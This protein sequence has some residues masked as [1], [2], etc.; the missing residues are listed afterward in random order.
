[1]E[2]WNEKQ[3]TPFN[4]RVAVVKNRFYLAPTFDFVEHILCG[5]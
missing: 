2:N 1:M 4:L 5:H 3:I